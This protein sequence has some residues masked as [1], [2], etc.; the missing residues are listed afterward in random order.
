[1]NWWPAL[2]STRRMR[3]L[4]RTRHLKGPEDLGDF[5]VAGEDDQLADFQSH[6]RADDNRKR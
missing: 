2:L 6:R 1:M 4:G 3:L 5:A